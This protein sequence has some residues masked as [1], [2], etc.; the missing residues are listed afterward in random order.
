MKNTALGITALLLVTVGSSDA[1]ASRYGYQ[2]DYNYNSNYNSNINKS[3]SRS[4]ANS[5][6]LSTSRA[7]GGNAVSAAT[8]GRATGF[9]GSSDNQVNI[10]GD[11]TTFRFPVSSAFA[12]QA[13]NNAECGR[14]GGIAGQLRNFGGSLGLPLSNNLDCDAD[15]DANWLIT[16]GYVDEAI[17]SKCQKRSMRR[18]HGGDAR[19]RKSRADNCYNELKTRHV[20]PV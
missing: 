6:S 8:G 16:L 14:A 13:I 20:A 3:R 9:G 4:A 10:G 2:N 17:K 7:T 15:N 11:T 19:G 12:P 5:D 18:A 1:F